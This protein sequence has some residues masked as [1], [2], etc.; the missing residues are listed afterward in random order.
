MGCCLEWSFWRFLKQFDKTLSVE[1]VKVKSVCSAFQESQKVLLAMKHINQINRKVSVDSF[2]LIVIKYHTF[3]IE[4]IIYHI[5][6]CMSK[7]TKKDVR[8]VYQNP[9]DTLAEELAKSLPNVCFSLMLYFQLEV[10]WWKENT[11]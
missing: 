10:L 8:V 3:I 7:R 1:R 4:S 5:S 11:F 2:Q 6:F 9:V